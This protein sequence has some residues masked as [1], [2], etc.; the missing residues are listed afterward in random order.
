[1]ATQ[2]KA[3]LSYAAL[4]VENGWEK[5]SFS[6][7]K[8]ILNE[9]QSKQHHQS[10]SYRPR[11][12]TMHE[13]PSITSSQHRLA[14][15]FPEFSSQTR[16]VT[17]YESFWANHSQRPT[18]ATSQPAFTPPPSN[19]RHRQTSSQPHYATF[20]R[21]KPERLSLTG[22]ASHPSSRSPISPNRAS[23]TARDQSAAEIMIALASP[24]TRSEFSSPERA[25]AGEE[26]DDEEVGGNSPTP[27]R[28]KKRVDV[29]GLGIH[30]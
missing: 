12:Q 25:A 3:R 16:N 17:S 6:E 2:L 24:R 1:L 4:K 30:T 13:S 10:P 20:P 8:N 21:R 18:Q 9:E 11:S 14:A 26:T 28:V 29:E 19:P 27:R 22:V 5:H 15:P 7:I 23:H